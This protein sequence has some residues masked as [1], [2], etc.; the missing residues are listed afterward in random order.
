MTDWLNK[1]L[2]KYQVKELLGR[3]AM[4]EIYK[5]F[6]PTLE[7]DV[8]IKVIHPQ[9]ADDP[10]FVDRF[11]HEAKV[12]AALRHPAIVQIYDFDTVDDTFY[13]VMEY[14]E[15][16]SLK[17][18]L[19]AIHEQGERMPLDKA[20]RL[21]RLVVEAVVYAHKQGVVHRDLKPSN[22]LLT[23]EGL[24]VLTDF[25]LSKI[26]RGERRDDLVGV[27]AGTPMYM[28]PEQGSGEAGDE[29]SDIYSLG[30][31]LY[32]LTTGVPPFNG[33]DPLD[34]ILKHLEE[35]FPPPRSINPDIP[36]SVEQ[37]IERALD[38]NPANRLYPAQELLE[39]LKEIVLPQPLLIADMA[40][41]EDTR[42]PYRGLRVFEEEHAEFY[43]GREAL[44]RQLLDKI[45]AGATF[46]FTLTQF[47]REE[48]R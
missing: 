30:V 40:Q 15:G 9:L 42:C 3:G 28:S 22:V 47:S 12:V 33:D 26:I 21:F 37:I 43:F 14:V 17:E 41:A 7:R 16:E 38:K 24:P 29:R 45:E 27:I 39:A 34:I 8:A 19:M 11:H 6:Q 4:A 32:E 1:Q 35:P 13:I 48:G 2:G 23:A 20:L 25:G 18:H 10:S 44:I 5:A 36:P 31:M 46:S